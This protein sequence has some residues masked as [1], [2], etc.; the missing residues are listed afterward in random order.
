MLEHHKMNRIECIECKEIKPDIKEYFYNSLKSR[1]CKKCILAKK[2]NTDEKIKKKCITCN[3]ESPA[4][5][6]FFYSSK[7]GKY[8]LKGKCKKCCREES[9]NIDIPPNQDEKI[10][11]T[12]T[13]CK[14]EKPATCDYYHKDKSNA[15]GLN[16]VCKEC[17]TEGKVNRVFQGKKKCATCNKI[18]PTTEFHKYKRRYRSKCKGCRYLE[19]KKYREKTKDDP[20]IKKGKKEYNR[21]RYQENAGVR[22]RSNLSR[23][24]NSFLKK[25]K[26]SQST[27]NLL[28]CSIKELKHY[29]ES[30]FQSGM[31]WDNYGSVDGDR[32]KGWQIDHIKPC[33]SFDLTKESEQKEC[34]HY[35]NLQPLWAI[36][37]IQKGDK[38]CE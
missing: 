16:Y 38:Y 26:D 29:L 31:S 7:T 9:K 27:L 24:I 28:G 11:R 15:I 22:I 6:E 8:G 5:K 20:A 14:E 17:R 4:T 13:S 21:K 19:G 37:N 34:F 33:S 18:K 10:L 23:R 12:C 36:D 2:S 25:E 1:R 30:L 35:T 32:M 3:K